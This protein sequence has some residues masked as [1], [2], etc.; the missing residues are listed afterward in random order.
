MNLPTSLVL[1]NYW[2]YKNNIQNIAIVVTFRRL[3]GTLIAREVPVFGGSDVLVI[4]PPDQLKLYGG[5][6][7]IEIWSVVDLRIPYAA[8]MVSY[9]AKKSLSMVHSYSRSYS[10]FEVEEGRTICVVREAWWRLRDTENVSPSASFTMEVAH[11][12]HRLWFLMFVIVMVIIC[13]QKS[14]FQS[15][16]HMKPVC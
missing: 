5:S 14:L 4:N 10:S 16:N 2:K 13:L 1:S 3:N 7:E 15:F 9:E 6:A 12:L 8:V 11:S